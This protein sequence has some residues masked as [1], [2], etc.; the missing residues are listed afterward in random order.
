MS[1]EFSLK[2]GKKGID[3]KENDDKFFG[4]DLF[5]KNESVVKIEITP[6]T[7]IMFMLVGAVI[8]LA[9]KL[10]SV[11]VMIFF[12]VVFA[13]AALPIVH[14]F[15]GKGLPKG[16]A[17]AIVYIFLIVAILSLASVIVVPFVGQLSKLT[18]QL[19]SITSNA[20]NSLDAL[21][22]DILNIDGTD[23]KNSAQGYINDLS[24]N[25]LPSLL[26]GS[27]GL[28]STVNT[29][30]G[31]GGSIL[32]VITILILSVYI[33]SDHDRVVDS[34]LIRI[35]DGGKRKMLRQLI[36]DVE[37]KLGKWLLGQ[38]FLSFTIGLLS[39]I[40]LTI[41]GVPF[42]LPLAVLAG[43][44][45][46][47][48]TLGPIISVVPSF[49]IALVVG[50]PVPAAFVLVAYVIIH[51]AENYLLVPKIMG[52][53]VGLHPMIVFIGI[54]AGV[55]LSGLLGAV[56]AVPVLVLIKIAYGFYRDLQKL[57]AKGIV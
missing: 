45:E 38:G 25:I 15:V 46:V 22:I 16:L 6:K 10:A 42:A 17:I 50:G 5:K 2:E 56:L 43:I 40:G 34:L 24:K 51:Q 49:L 1:K 55:S 8:F 54:I 29:L 53:V 57:R 31:V 4:Y 35:V 41:I 47:V 30:M 36:I 18:D 20:L 7:L 28:I 3:V 37:N 12:A 32:T 21:H 23:I 14:W 26:N 11:A 44:M 13:S 33:I 52:G 39:W 9:L 19:P 27:N 48:P